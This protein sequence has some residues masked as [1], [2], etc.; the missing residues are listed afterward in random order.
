MINTSSTLADPSLSTYAAFLRSEKLEEFVR[1]Q[2]EQSANLEIPVLKLLNSESIEKIIEYGR[3]SAKELLTCFENNAQELFI[4]KSVNRI[5]NDE[6]PGISKGEIKAEDITMMNLLRRKALFHFL[7]QFVSDQHLAIKIV[8]EIATFFSRLETRMINTFLEIFRDSL[9]EEFYF[10]Q[11]LTNTT[12]GILYVLELDSFNVIYTNERAINFLGYTQ[13]DL[14]KMG[15]HLFYHVIYKEDLKIVSGKKK[16]FEHASDNDVVVLEFRLI[17]R[18]GSAKWIRNYES[19][20]KRNEQGVPTQVIGI[21]IDINDEK[22]ISQKLSIREQQLV[23]SE[24]LYKQAQSL[25]HIGN[26]SWELKTGKVYWSEELYR[27]Y[28]LE[29]GQSSLSYNRLNTFTH[30]HDKERT[31]LTIREAIVNKNPFDFHYRIVLKNDKV[32]ILHAKGEISVGENGEADAVLGT[33][34]DVTE[35]QILLKKLQESNESLE[36]FAYIASHDLQEPLRKIST[37]GDRLTTQIDNLNPEGQRFLKKIVESSVRMQQM[38]NDLLSVSVISNENTFSHVN[39]NSLLEEVLMNLEHKIEEKKAAIHYELLPETYV[40][41]SQFRQLFQNLISNS[42]KFSRPGVP[43]EIYITH[44]YTDKLPEHY[45]RTNKPG[46]YLVIEVRDNGIG[47]NNAYAEKIFAIFQRLHGKHEY[48]GTGIGLAIC[49]KIVE[50]HGG[51]I[52]A[53]GMLD[54]GTTFTI[55][56]PA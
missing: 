16:L 30:P 29:P 56:I 9:K 23:E 35:L 34:Q 55:I 52:R 44:N 5:L 37:F 45:S 40:I 43:L 26:Y 33:I 7:P 39:L 12:P 42:L 6:I 38:I 1:F 8:T 24:K 41:P 31:D 17:A 10:K 15:K 28:E 13:D 48:E 2:L 54:V 22:N 32:K 11:K 49:K 46:K 4:E 20:F 53:N 50:H 51:V 47:I 3:Q 25:T 27:I 21:A 19:I 14:I 36:E 18:D